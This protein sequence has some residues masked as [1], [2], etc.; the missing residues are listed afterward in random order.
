MSKLS[1]NILYLNMCYSGIHL[2]RKGTE[3]SGSREY[4]LKYKALNFV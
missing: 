2:Q 3:I 4:I 1:Q